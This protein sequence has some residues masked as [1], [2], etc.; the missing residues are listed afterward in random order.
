M[1]DVGSLGVSSDVLL[2]AMERVHDAVLDGRPA[3]AIATLLDHLARLCSEHFATEV[4]VLRRYGYTHLDARLV[5][6]A[7]V[8]S[9]IPGMRERI[10]AGREE[11][12]GIVDLLQTLRVLTGKAGVYPGAPRY[13]DSASMLPAAY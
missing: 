9:K 8:L 13:H 10:C 5:M 12:A 11:T 1:N 2:T 4:R 3:D 7:R 6:H